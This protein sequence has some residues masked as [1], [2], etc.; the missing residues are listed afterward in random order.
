MDFRGLIDQA[1]LV[2][3]LDNQTRWVSWTRYSNRQRQRMQWE[4]MIG[5]AVYDAGAAAQN[6][7][8][9]LAPFWKFAKFAGFAHVGHGTTF[10]L[11]KYALQAD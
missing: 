9:P 4:G 8:R 1:G 11:G 10:G 5:R 2:R 7:G 6:K 3:L